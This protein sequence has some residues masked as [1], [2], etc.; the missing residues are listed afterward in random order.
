MNV[1]F[2]NNIQLYKQYFKYEP[3]YCIIRIITSI[4]G[5]VQPISS[6]YLF[7]IFL[8]AI[9]IDKSLAK[10]ILM[11]LMAAVLNLIVAIINW[12]VNNKLTPISEQKNM[13]RYTKEL[14]HKYLNTDIEIIED[15]AFYDKYTQVINDISNRIMAVQN[16]VCS[17]IGNI[18]SL[19]VVIALMLQVG[20]VMILVSLSGVVL[21]LFL[22]P[23]MNK[24]GYAS[25]MEKTSFV[26][27][28]DY[29]KR[30]FYIRDYMKELKIYPISKT[31]LDI[32]NKNSNELI[33]VCKKYGNKYILYG[34]IASLAQC[35]S[36]A[37]VLG[38]LAYCALFK[39]WSMGY[40]ASMYNASDELK[41]VIGQL[42]ATIPLFDENSRYITNYNSLI[43]SKSII[44][45]KNGSSMNEKVDGFDFIE[46][47]GVEFTYKNSDK[48]VLK[49]IDFKIE[50]GSRYAIV[51]HNGAGKSTF[52]N[53][54]LRLYNP[55]KGTIL[56]NGLEYER[57]DVDDLRQ[58]FNVVLQDCQVYAVTIAEN[59]LLREMKTK[60]D[61]EHVWKALDKVGLKQYVEDLPNGINSIVT[62]EF[63]EDGVIFSGGQLQKILLART[64]ANDAPIIVLDEVTSAM[65]AI[66]ENAMYNE[67]E[68]FAEGKTLIYISHKLSTTKGADG[69]YVFDKGCISE[70]GTHEQ[71]MKKEGVYAKMFSVQAEKYGI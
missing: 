30:V 26:R 58:L 31:F 23:I 5:I 59:I 32:I 50:K 4:L 29:I 63:T 34:V 57:Y 28:Q 53:L 36:F 37:L 67:I 56:L 40:V 16:S 11:A 1:T 45:N 9:F 39:G 41:N 24:L 42:F 48:K 60:D 38:Y 3:G 12:T 15:P 64:F 22:S 71:L 14:L 13:L 25:Y 10:S 6:I 17:L 8:D 52:I 47:K 51:G 46:F 2:K 65:D 43:A 19:S 35:F 7:Q 61:E 18:C 27:K 33:E 68:K 55:T 69:I 66:S 21:N 62:K 70:Q 54:L 20:P 44:E 49:N